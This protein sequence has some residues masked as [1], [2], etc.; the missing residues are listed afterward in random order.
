MSKKIPNVKLRRKLAQENTGAPVARTRRRTTQSV[1]EALVH[2][3]YDWASSAWIESSR[4]LSELLEKK[5]ARFWALVSQ[6]ANGAPSETVTE[7]VIDGLYTRVVLMAR[8]MYARS[9]S[10][11]WGEE[12]WRLVDR[13]LEV[14][15]A[16]MARAI[17][18][19]GDVNT[20]RLMREADLRGVR[21]WDLLLVLA[22]LVD[23]LCDDVA[24][25]CELRRSQVYAM[26]W[27]GAE[28]ELSL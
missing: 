18:R 28:D 9:S 7:A 21:L 26:V 5:A 24:Q 23:A 25:V 15:N 1:E 14:H 10:P 3:E 13:E 4:M 17:R 22:A 6:R 2:L 11:V 12:S 19:S 27:D 16:W 20:K 8:V